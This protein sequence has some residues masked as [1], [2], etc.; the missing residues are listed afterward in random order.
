MAGL[1]TS[2]LE[3]AGSIL[4]EPVDWFLTARDI[5]EDW[6]DDGRIRPDTVAFAAMGF[7]PVVSSRFLF[8]PDDIAGGAARRG[9]SNIDD[10]IPGTPEH[11]AIRWSQYQT[12]PDNAG[13]SY[14]RWSS[15][16]DMQRA[17]IA[18]ERV[19]Q[20]ARTLDWGT[21]VQS[22]IS[23]G[24]FIR[25]LDIVDTDLQ[26]GIEFKSGRYFYRDRTIVEQIRKDAFLVANENWTI[27]WVF[28]VSEGIS[29]P[30]LE[31]LIDAGISVKIVTFVE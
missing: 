20:Y 12:N 11:K 17:R 27:E 18:Q 8:S 23:A 21:T 24:D 14:E 10:L 19:E 16:Y 22:N 31:Q 26:R 28:E 15:N 9:R 6:R 25:R 2:A 4:F 3:I 29:T 5:Y 30:L 7:L 13:W 1:V